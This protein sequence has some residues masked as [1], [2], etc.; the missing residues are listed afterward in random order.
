MDKN[1]K[2]E[3]NGTKLDKKLIKVDK[4]VKTDDQESDI[5]ERKIKERKGKGSNG[6]K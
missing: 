3:K 1:G 2:C 6:R 4:M 5:K